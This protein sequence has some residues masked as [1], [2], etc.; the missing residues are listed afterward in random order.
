MLQ[1]LETFCVVAEAGSLTKA[2]QRLHLT[3]PAITRQMRALERDLGTVLL[4][5][6]PQ[7][8]ALTPAG[9]AVLE[10]A[11]EA[12]AAVRAVRQAATEVS[13]AGLARLRVAAGLMATQYVLP[14]VVAAFQA[15]HPGVEVELQPVHQRVAVERLLG[16]EVDVAV[17]ASPV[18]SPL[19]KAT[20]VQ[21]DPLMVI[22]A[23]RSG[24]ST[25]S[26]GAVGGAD[27]MRLEELQEKTLLVLAPGTGLHELVEEALRQRG[28]TCHLMEHPN[29]ETIKTAVRLGMGLTILPSSA[30]R[31][32]LR[33][34]TLSARTIADWPGGER[35]IRV[36]VRS[37]GRVPK[38]VS[39]FV[40]LLKEILSPTSR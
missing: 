1:L 34:G 33:A 22:G 21:R 15:R 12:I 13:G 24:S 14:P 31:E 36:L 39:E 19:V 25:G 30:V 11:R 23:G 27:P 40:T 28:V 8:V 10:H 29:A 20:P 26:G 35:M 37:S 17:I 9:R 5:R 32:E 7:G 16:Y 6:T 3:Q 4:T 38:V 18:Q 2:A